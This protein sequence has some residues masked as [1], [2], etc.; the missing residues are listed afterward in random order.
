[1]KRKG[2]YQIKNKI[3]EKKYI[4][5]SLDIDKRL[6]SHLNSLSNGTHIN[7]HLQKDYIKYGEETFEVSIIEECY[8]RDLNRKESEHCYTNDVWNPKKGYNKGA[9]KDYRLLSKEDAIYYKNKFLIRLFSDDNPK[10]LKFVIYKDAEIFGLDY[11]QI[12]IF[13]E[14]IT[15]ED[16]NKYGCFLDVRENFF[17]GKLTITVNQYKDFENPFLKTKELSD[18][19]SVL[20][21]NNSLTKEELEE[22]EKL[23]KQLYE[24]YLYNLE[25]LLS[26]VSLREEIK[27]HLIEEFILGVIQ[28]TVTIE[29]ASHIDLIEDYIESFLYDEDIKAAKEFCSIVNTYSYESLYLDDRFE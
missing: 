20:E 26:R 14:E 10:Q 19:L 1:M 2:I 24:R 22:M 29:E 15:E 18:K 27:M 13:L 7:K 5:Q 6:K 25:L 17:E 12:R 16:T 4:G 9:L 28:T 8:P 23:E 21:N 3:N 11:T